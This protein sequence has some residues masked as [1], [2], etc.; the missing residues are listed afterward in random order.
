M[1]EAIKSKINEKDEYELASILVE[2]IKQLSPEDLEDLKKNSHY[3]NVLDLLQL[4]CEQN[5][6]VEKARNFL[7]S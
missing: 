1:N 3:E 5:I 6:I 2:I 7:K 4:R